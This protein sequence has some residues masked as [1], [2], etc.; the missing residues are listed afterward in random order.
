METG[1][2]SEHAESPPPEIPDN[3]APVQDFSHLMQGNPEETQSES[4]ET[5][6]VDIAAV[7][8]GEDAELKESIGVDNEAI[9][10]AVKQVAETAITPTDSVMNAAS[11][12]MMQ[13]LEKAVS[14]D[15]NLGIIQDENSEIQNFGTPEQ[16][17]L[18]YHEQNNPE[19]TCVQ[20]SCEGII[21]KHFP[22]LKG[23]VSEESL[24]QEAINAGI[25]TSAGT[26]PAYIKQT[27][28]TYGIPAMQRYGAS[29]DIIKTEL[30]QGHDIIVG[31]DPGILWNDDDYRDKGHAIRVTGI[32]RDHL[33]AYLEVTVRD[34]G[35]SRIDGKGKIPI[36]Q[37]LKAWRPLNNF[38]VSTIHSAAEMKARR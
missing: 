26:P 15:A 5:N 9:E 1:Y 34:S 25:F 32:S 22:D 36:E 12:L 38:M 14:P 30:E 7:I 3:P 18:D 24:K 17:A 28:E 37:F 8:Q 2:E 6:T 19:Q 20:A 10:D 11:T 16:D 21:H 23:T 29:L 31:V 33:G 4:M 27:L 13:G 35:T